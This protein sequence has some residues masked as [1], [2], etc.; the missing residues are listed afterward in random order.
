MSNS[1]LLCDPYTD[2]GI[3]GA[4]SCLAP[5]GPANP[6]LNITNSPST[7]GSA[8]GQFNL[9]ALVACCVTQVLP[10]GTREQ[11]GCF[12]YCRADD[13]EGS[14]KMQECFK[15]YKSRLPD[16]IFVGLKCDERSGGDDARE[17]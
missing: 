13:E 11:K 1:T 6:N 9:D 4:F 3:P 5:T 17:D 12:H 8:S 15:D 2:I 7:Y 14:L 16:H 10:Y